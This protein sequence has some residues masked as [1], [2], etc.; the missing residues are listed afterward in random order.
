MGR[1]GLM[2]PVCHVLAGVAC[3]LYLLRASPETYKLLKSHFWV[4]MAISICE[5][6]SVIVFLVRRPDLSLSSGD[7]K[8]LR[9][10]SC[11]SSSL[12]TLAS[13]TPPKAA[14]ALPASSLECDFRTA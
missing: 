3:A 4:L 11:S 5:V 6:A 12:V 9:N 7:P 14:S 8:H 2:C 1:W 13:R 10:K